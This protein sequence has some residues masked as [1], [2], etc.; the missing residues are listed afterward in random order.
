MNRLF[1]FFTPFYSD[2]RRDV[3]IKLSGHI[4][5]SLAPLVD[6]RHCAAGCRQVGKWADECTPRFKRQSEDII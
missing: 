2:Q 6:I 3:L 5:V 4:I 1:L